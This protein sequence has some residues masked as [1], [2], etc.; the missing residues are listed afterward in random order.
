MCTMNDFNTAVIEEFRANEGKVGGPFANATLLL[1]HH[2]GAKSGQQRVNPLAYQKVGDAHAVFASKAG[3]STDPDWYNNLLAHP[4]TTVEVGT[5]TIQ[6]RARVAG[7]S[8]RDEIYARQ[9]ER[10]PQFGEYVKEAAPRVIPVVILDP[11]T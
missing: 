7:P 1:L 5:R 10:A 11:I 3:A 4:E 9:V 6:V 8:E 2:T